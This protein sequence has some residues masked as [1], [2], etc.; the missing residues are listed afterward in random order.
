[1]R[2]FPLRTSLAACLSAVLVCTLVFSYA[3][4]QAP[5]APGGSY[6]AEST[7]QTQESTAYVAEQEN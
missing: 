2:A 6:I 7:E 5:T 4:M 1:M 3:L